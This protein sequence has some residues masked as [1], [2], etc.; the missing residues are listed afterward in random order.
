MGKRKFKILTMFLLFCLVGGNLFGCQSGI[1]NEEVVNFDET[2]YITIDGTKFA[3]PLKISDIESMGYTVDTASLGLGDDNKLLPDMHYSEYISILKD[4]NDIGVKCKV[5][6][7]SSETKVIDDCSIYSLKF[8][9]SD[10]FSLKDGVT[11]GSSEEEFTK[12][13]GSPLVKNEVDGITTIKYADDDNGFITVEIAKDTSI[14]IEYSLD[15]E[16]AQAALN[17]NSN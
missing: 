15:D 10:T 12:V 3:I 7:V 2:G 6:N 9:N 11:V 16:E 5:V 8:S 1:S 13:F 17:K 14:T 4:G